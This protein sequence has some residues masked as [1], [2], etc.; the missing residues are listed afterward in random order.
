M[1]VKKYNVNFIPPMQFRRAGPFTT[2]HR[3]NDRHTPCTNHQ[4]VTRLTQ[5]DRQPFTATANFKMLMHI[6]N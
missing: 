3:A 4:P 1:Y 5:S 2:F 6:L